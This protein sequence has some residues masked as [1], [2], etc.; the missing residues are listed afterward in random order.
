MSRKKIAI[1]EF[2]GGW[3]ISCAAIVKEKL[4]CVG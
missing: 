2:L 4:Y 3:C 1:T